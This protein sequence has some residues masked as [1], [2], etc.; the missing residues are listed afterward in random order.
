ML[1][2]KGVYA[3]HHAVRAVGEVE[4][5]QLGDGH[6]K[7]VAVRAAVGQGKQHGGRAGLGLP[8]TLHG[9]DLGGLVV[10]GVEAMQITDNDLQRYQHCGQVDTSFQAGQ[11]IG[12]P[13]LA[14]PT[15][16]AHASQQEAHGQARGQQHVGEAVGEGGVE[17]HLHPAGH[18]GLAVHHLKARRRV[19]PGV[20]RQ[21]PERRS[22]GAHGHQ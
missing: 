22:R 20:E 14:Q 11:H 5:G 13:V 12:T 1:V 8:N 4:R 2:A 17:D 21:D 10:Q 15:V 7:T 18:M 19:H 3:L 6:F 9:G 16:G